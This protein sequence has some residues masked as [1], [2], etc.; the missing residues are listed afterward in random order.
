MNKTANGETTKEMTKEDIKY[1][2][3]RF[4]NAAKLAKQSGVDGVEI[5]AAHGYLLNQFLTP[6]HNRR[7]DEYGGTLENRMRIVVEVY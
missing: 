6:L 5:H 7:T 4:A 2:I 3:S 1:I